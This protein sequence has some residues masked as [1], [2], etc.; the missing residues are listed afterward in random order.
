MYGAINLPR[1]QKKRGR[2][3]ISGSANLMPARNLLFSFSNERRETLRSPAR[4]ARLVTVSR[5]VV[6]KCIT[7]KTCADEY[8]NS[9]SERASRAS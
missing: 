1:V 4:P 3:E 8:A 6:Y 9:R 5:N 7:C 2:K